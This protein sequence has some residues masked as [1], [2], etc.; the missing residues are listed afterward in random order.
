MVKEGIE[1]EVLSHN[2]DLE[3]PTAASTISQALNVAQEVALRTSELTAISIL[4]GEMVVQMGKDLSQD[5]AY[6]SVLQ[7]VRRE[8]HLVASEPELPDVFDFLRSLGVGKNSYADQLLQ[9]GAAFVDSKK[10]Q[11]RFSAFAVVNKVN[12]DYPLSR[13]AIIKR[14]Y[15]AKPSKGFCPNPEAQWQK[16]ENESFEKLEQL[17]FYFHETRRP[18][19]QQ[20]PTEEQEKFLANVD[21]VVVDGFFVKASRTGRWKSSLKTIE[22]TL[23]QSTLK[24]FEQ[25]EEEEAAAAE[26]EDARDSSRE[27]DRINTAVAVA[28]AVADAN[29]EEEN[30]AAKSTKWI[31]FSKVKIPTTPVVGEIAPR[32]ATICRLARQP[33]RSS[34]NEPA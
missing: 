24:F 6:K 33:S 14:A 7:Q 15:R 31:D 30:N 9:F 32:T 19:V 25:L 1:V 34:T 8:L 3:E 27:D 2:I 22:E 12:H 23:L 5:V 21:C 10:R 16:I 11:L 28:T 29:K 18:T 4:K 26:I 13:V 17:L 20:L